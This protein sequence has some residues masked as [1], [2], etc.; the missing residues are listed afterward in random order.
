MFIFAIL[1]GVFIYNYFSRED[2]ANKIL[3]NVENEEF[4]VKE[5][6]IFGT[7][8]SISGCIDTIVDGKLSLIL[9]NNDKEI[10]V[11]SKFLKDESTTCFYTSEKNNEGLNLDNLENG[12]YILL[13]KNIEN[14]KSIYYT[15][16]NNT[17]YE[18][19]E[20]YTITKNDK[21]K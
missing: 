11:D 12:K 1:V 7:S 5:Y 4:Y 13:V 6:S 3:N 16:R 15:L 19:L 8:F 21:N 20:Y 17:D 18:N 14:E 9:K 10:N 2:Y